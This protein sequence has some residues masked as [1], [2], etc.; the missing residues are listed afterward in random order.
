MIKFNY[1]EYCQNYRSG[2]FLRVDY[3]EVDFVEKTP[4]KSVLANV[5]FYAVW[6]ILKQALFGSD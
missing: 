1:F 3:V 5:V 2:R 6:E 4:T